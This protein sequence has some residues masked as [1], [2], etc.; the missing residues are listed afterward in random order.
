M[1]FSRISFG[2]T[3]VPHISDNS[4]TMSYIKTH[5]DVFDIVQMQSFEREVNSFV[6]IVYKRRYANL[7]AI[8]YHG[9]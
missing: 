3:F 4:F 2:A 9:P 7:S 5:L 1:Y 8:T 6:I